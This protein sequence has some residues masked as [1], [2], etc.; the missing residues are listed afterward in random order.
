[1]TLLAG[2]ERSHPG[3]TSVDGFDETCDVVIVGSGAGGSVMA[4]ILAE[5][6][7]QRHRAR[8]R[9]VL[10]AGRVRR[11]SPDRIDAPHLARSRGCS[12]RS[13]WG[14]RRSSGFRRG[15]S[16]GGS[17]VLT[18]GVCFRIPSEVHET[19]CT[20]SVS[21]SCR[22]E[23][24]EGV[25]DVERR[26]G[27]DR[28]ARGDAF[29]RRPRSSSKG[30]SGSASPFTPRGATPKDASATRGAIRLP[31]RRQDVGR[32]VVFARRALGHGARVVSD[33]LVERVIDR[34]RARRRASCGACS[35]ATRDGRRTVPRAR[36]HRSSSACGT[37][38][39]PDLAPAKR[40]RATPTPALGR[41]VTL[42]PAL[43]VS[44]LSTTSSTGWNGALQSVYSDHF[45]RRGDHARRR[46]LAGQRARRGA[47]GVGP[48]H[49]ST[50]RRCRITAVF[51][52]MVHDEGGGAVRLG[53]GR[54]P[55]LP[56]AWPRA[57]CFACVIR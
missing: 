29:G 54:E 46:L 48:L 27:C 26:V 3:R 23:P 10:H 19:G 14:R 17:S 43:R 39:T 13:A 44:A 45:A 6:G 1:M 21:T 50:S 22:S 7:Q 28:G 33:A 36:A 24:R 12:P 40:P 37:L 49:R 4:A 5:A 9:A 52:A 55:V 15:A 38:H 31:E 42:H 30:P 56:T 32:R 16:V 47:P 51:G 18:G 2:F 11:L 57:I 35:A 41:N 8:R 34:A 53:T 25:P 20:S